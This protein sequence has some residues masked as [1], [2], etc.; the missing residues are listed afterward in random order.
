[1]TPQP[2]E[3]KVDSL[4]HRMTQLEQQLGPDDREPSQVVP[5]RTELR[6]ECSSVRA[7]IAEQGK[8]LRAE[9]AEQGQALRGEIAGL[10]QELRGEIAGQGKSL[11]GD[12]EKLG[13]RIDAQGTQMRVL[14]EEVISRIALLQEGQPASRRKRKT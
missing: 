5:L 4:E 3:S 2:L 10:G 14:H 6:A 1:M 11:R 13:T 8:T 7:E 9:I 12:I